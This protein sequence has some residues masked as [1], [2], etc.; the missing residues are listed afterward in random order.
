MSWS[1][2][3]FQVCED[4]FTVLAYADPW[5]RMNCLESLKQLGYAHIQIVFS[6][7]RPHPC[8][9]S[10]TNKYTMHFTKNISCILSRLHHALYPNPS[11]RRVQDVERWRKTGKVLPC[12]MLQHR[13]KVRTC[14]LNLV[15]SILKI[16]YRM[17]EKPSTDQFLTLVWNNTRIK[18]IVFHHAV[19]KPYPCLEKHVCVCARASARGCIIFSRCMHVRLYSVNKI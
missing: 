5:P 16:L 15:L 4:W 18:R 3:S 9:A 14:A 19:R 10:R 8:I 2:Q 1:G 7:S 12:S 6:S 13:S 17:V 11:T